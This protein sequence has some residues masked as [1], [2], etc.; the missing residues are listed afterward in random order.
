[1]TFVS[2]IFFLYGHRSKQEQ[3]KPIRQRLKFYT[4][5]TMYHN[6]HIRH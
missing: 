5:W 4:R 2:P 3:A 1:L 6:I